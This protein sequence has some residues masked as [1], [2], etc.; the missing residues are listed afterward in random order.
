MVRD[1]KEESSYYYSQETMTAFAA[2]RK[3]HPRAKL[4]LHETKEAPQMRMVQL[5]MHQFVLNMSK[6]DRTH[7]MKPNTTVRR[8]WIIDRLS[9]TIQIQIPSHAIPIMRNAE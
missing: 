7:I 5:L 4:S 3:M 8:A 6:A 9:L 1:Y 2:R